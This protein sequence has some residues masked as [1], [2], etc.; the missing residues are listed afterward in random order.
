MVSKCGIGMLLIK[1]HDETLL[2]V[3]T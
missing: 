3:D 1:L 2:Q